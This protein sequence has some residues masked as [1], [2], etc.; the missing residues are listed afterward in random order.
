MTYRANIHEAKTH[1]SRLL[2]LAHA[3][4]EVIVAKAGRDYVRIVPI[5]GEVNR[6]AGAFRGKIQGDVLSPVAL[7]DDEAWG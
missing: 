6:K 7:D 4:E 5:R 3:G 1:F 2:Q